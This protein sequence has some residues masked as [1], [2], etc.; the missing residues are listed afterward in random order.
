MTSYELH[1]IFSTDCEPF[2]DWQSILLLHSAIA[3]GISSPVTR[4]AS[5]CNEPKKTYLRDLYRQLFP[6]YGIH[7][8][9]CFKK[10]NKTG[11]ICTFHFHHYFCIRLF[12]FNTDNFYNKPWGLKH[13]LEHAHPPVQE[14]IVVALLDPDMIFLRPLSIVMRGQPNILYDRNYY[15]S[16]SDIIEKIVEQKPAAQLYGLGAPWT[17]DNHKKFNRTFVCGPGSPCLNV[18]ERFGAHHYAVGPPYIAHKN[19]MIRIANSWTKF[20]TRYNNRHV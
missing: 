9:P 6:A 1:I 12:S 16:P 7:F 17:N 2:Q 3:V 15:K 4:I 19:D 13:W 5:G 8:T 11:K 18:N 10:D 14:G 20:V